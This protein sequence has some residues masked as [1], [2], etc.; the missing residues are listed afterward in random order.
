M[1]G[2]ISS[3]IQSGGTSSGLIP[4]PLAHGMSQNQRSWRHVRSQGRYLLGMVEIVSLSRQ[5]CAQAQIPERAQL[6]GP[7]IKDSFT[8]PSKFCA[9]TYEI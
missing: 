6:Y 4:F 1:C 7:L 2:W 8:F 5:I 3:K 9:S